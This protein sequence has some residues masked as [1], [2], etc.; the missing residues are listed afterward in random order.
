VPLSRGQGLQANAFFET[1]DAVLNF[2]RITAELEKGDECGNGEDYQP[3][4]EVVEVFHRIAKHDEQVYGKDGSEN[5]V[6]GRVETPVVLETLR[7]G[8][9][10][11]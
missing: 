11:A 8:I 4:G 3:F 1:D 6:V 5:K 2:E 9:T 7:G 10:H